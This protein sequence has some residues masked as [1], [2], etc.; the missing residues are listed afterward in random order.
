MPLHPCNTTRLLLPHPLTPFSP[1]L[2][3]LHIPR[4]VPHRRIPHMETA[5]GPSLSSRCI[6]L[7]MHYTLLSYGHVC[8]GWACAFT[9]D[10]WV[11]LGVRGHMIKLRQWGTTP[12]VWPG[13]PGLGIT[14]HVG[15]H[16]FRTSVNPPC[17]WWHRGSGRGKS[18]LRSPDEST[19]GSEF[20][21]RQHKVENCYFSRRIKSII[22]R[23][24]G[25]LHS[26]F[27]GMLLCEM[28][29]WLEFKHHFL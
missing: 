25:C 8:I 12:W 6:I 11:S 27:A 15:W 16:L 21:W 29:H 23:S 18:C 19:A 10:L 22:K 5:Q 28:L 4:Q 20:K 2:T 9:D 24:W 14:L 26:L 13:H 1:L 17:R 7:S 3:R